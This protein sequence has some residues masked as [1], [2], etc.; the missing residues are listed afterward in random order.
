[1]KIKNQKVHNLLKLDFSV[2]TL[3]D[4]VPLLTKEGKGEKYV[5]W[6]G[7]LGT[8]L[9]L[10][11]TALEIYTK[12]QSPPSED[13]GY[14]VTIKEED[15]LFDIVHN[16]AVSQMPQQEQRAIEIY[17]LPSYT[18][19]QVWYDDD[20]E[21]EEEE[22]ELSPQ[23]VGARW[24]AAT[25]A[26]IEIEGHPIYLSIKTPEPKV[27]KENDS[28][29]ALSVPY[30]VMRS[31]VFSMDT[32]EA[33]NAL[34]RL[35][36]SLIPPAKVRKMV[37]RVFIPR[38]SSW[39]VKM[40]LPTRDLNTVIIPEKDKR[41]IL[42]ELDSFFA[43][44]Q[45]YADLGLPWHRGYLFTGPPGTGKTSLARALASHYGMH[46]YYLSL[47]DVKMDDELISLVSAVPPKSMLLIEDIDIACAATE[48]SNDTGKASLAGL[49]N[50]LDGFA[51]P[52]GLVK[53]MTTNHIE[54]LDD[55]L[56]RP[57][58]T[59]HIL[60]VGYLGRAE[61]KALVKMATGR[62]LPDSLYR[63]NLTAAEVLEWAKKDFPHKNASYKAITEHLTR[64]PSPKAFATNGT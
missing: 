23:R 55:A 63:P 22:P 14:T 29:S 2:D 46:V 1:M 42:D 4:A 37:P 41:S 61:L 20:E 52:H 39:D 58:R 44:E 11:H 12:L 25:S 51:T 17:T 54:R 33:R 45:L 24:S 49:L 5:K 35:I 47:S 48:R 34:L 59:D 10:R 64:L 8:A 36:N 18:D 40:S 62:N 31:V 56:L 53:V 3:L 15:E 30:V 19:V 7:Y 16:W 27:G 28:F 43:N 57:G 50:V 9:A 26:K 32:I 13:T 6:A 38:F 21:E 60:Q